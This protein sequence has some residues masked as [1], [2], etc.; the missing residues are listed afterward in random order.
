MP[1]LS[2]WDTQNAKILFECCESMET[3][4]DIF[5]WN[6]GNIK[7]MKGIF[8]NCHSLKVLP[9]LSKWKTNNAININHL[10][11]KFSSLNNLPDI[12]N[13]NVDKVIWKIYFI[14]VHPLNY[15]LIY[16]IGKLII[17]NQ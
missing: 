12:S 4:P 8:S 3:L 10:F 15:Y 11:E 16:Q 5:C 9:D 17:L 7:E 1:D 14:L 6:V 2:K 13:W